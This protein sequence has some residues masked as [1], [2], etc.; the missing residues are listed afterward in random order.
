MGLHTWK[1]PAVDFW[2]LATV[3]GP[4]KVHLGETAAAPVGLVTELHCVG[5]GLAWQTAMW[6]AAMGFV[7]V[8]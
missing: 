8:T 4:L 5:L 1:L 2:H 7:H 3:A 6:A